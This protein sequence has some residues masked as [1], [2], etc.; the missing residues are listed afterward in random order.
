MAPS[1]LIADSDIDIA[2]PTRSEVALDG[3][4]RAIRARRFSRRQR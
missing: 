2:A 1:A 3:E 4:P